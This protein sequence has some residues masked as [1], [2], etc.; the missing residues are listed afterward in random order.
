MHR[1]LPDRQPGGYKAAY[2]VSYNR[3]FDGTLATDNGMSDPFYAEYQL[4]RFLERNGYDLSYVA[5]KDVDSNGPLLQNHKV[6]I[7]NGHDEYW[8]AGERQSVEAARNAG[9]NLAFFSGNELF[10]KTRW[11]SSSADGTSTPYR[12]GSITRT[13]T[14]TH[15]STPPIRR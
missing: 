10:W 6:F 12:T 4:I 9:V 2:A 14:S 13:P 3:P 1:L 5:Q 11:A 7:S 8:A 15:R